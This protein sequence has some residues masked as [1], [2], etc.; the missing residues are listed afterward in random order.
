MAAGGEIRWPPL[1]RMSC[2]LSGV[3]LLAEAVDVETVM[4]TSGGQIGGDGALPDPPLQRA[5]GD[6]EGAG[7][8]TR[9][10]K[11]RTRHALTVGREYGRLTA[12]GAFVST[13]NTW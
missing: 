6:A 10:D 8:F 1:G 13:R 9:R 3:E 5:H 2:P 4:T 7:S 12:C 11:R